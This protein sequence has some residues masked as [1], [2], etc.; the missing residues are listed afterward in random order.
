[1]SPAAA[2]PSFAQASRDLL[3][4]TVLD[5]VGA[6]AAERPWPEVSMADV[7]ERAGVSRQTL[8]NAFGSRQEMAQDYVMREAERFL[9]AVTD[10]IR[11]NAPDGR[12]ALEAAL[13]I[14]LS[15]AETH[16]VIRA[17]T[18]SESGDELLPLLTTRGGPLV[19]EITDRLAALLLESWGELG[20]GDAQV[21]ADCLVR[22]AISHAALPAG[23][24]AETAATL[25][26][27]LGPFVDALPGAGS[28]T[29]PAR[30]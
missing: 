11:S 26:R 15:A 4:E 24:P 25:A 6:L 14:F 20:T 1:V 28:G 5:A 12:A 22:L 2:K 7:A 30:L 9:A 3:R 27:V 21:V 19:T 16:P 17:V 23:H 29:Q 8:Y 13:A 18:A 10:A